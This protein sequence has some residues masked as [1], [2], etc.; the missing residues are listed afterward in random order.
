[1]ATA[2]KLGILGIDAATNQAICA[3]F[4]NEDLDRDFLFFYLMLIRRNILQSS[5]GG[6]QPNISQT[7]I[8]RLLVPIPPLTVQQRIVSRIKAL[9][10]DLKEA[11]STLD[12]M[13]H[14][15]GQVMNSASR[16]VF[17]EVSKNNELVSLGPHTTKMGSGSTPLGDNYE[18]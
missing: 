16:E 8:N 14:D 13:R 17:K 12:S 6:A 15:I 7:F 2:G 3:I 10:A 4:P 11:Q 9:L 5:T 1:G 18:E